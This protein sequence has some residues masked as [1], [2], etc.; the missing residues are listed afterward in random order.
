[1]DRETDAE[2]AARLFAH[3]RE[4][5]S[6]FV[7]GCDEA[8]RAALAGPLVTAAVCLEL[9]VVDTERLLGVNDSKSVAK[10][11][12]GELFARVSEQAYAIH[13]EVT[14]AAQSDKDGIQRANMDGLTACLTEVS[15]LQDVT[16]LVDWYR[17]GECAPVHLSIVKGDDKA[18]RSPLP[19]SSRR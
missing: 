4:F 14:D 1:M 3:D 16:C 5:G 8:G 11:R 19:R 7:A 10:S 9:G 13:V 15:R 6:R 12:H 18:R 17:L 2:I